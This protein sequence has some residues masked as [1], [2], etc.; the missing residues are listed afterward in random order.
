MWN[1]IYFGSLAAAAAFTAFL[2]YYTWT[3]LGSIGAPADAIAGF[4]YWH[5]LLRNVLWFLSFALLTLGI[6][7]L[8]KTKQA[9]NLWI[10]FGFFTSFAIF[11]YFILVFSASTFETVRGLPP[12]SSFTAPI[13]TVLLIAGF[14][15]LVFSAHFVT[16]KFVERLYPEK[17]PDAEDPE[18]PSSAEPKAETEE[19][20][21]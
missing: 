2:A 16:L 19:Q 21:K 4:E 7:S 15:G 6:I 11:T 18:L 14:G 9:W 3:W 8:V 10:T 20:A 5:F 12:R 1:K 13:I 17:G